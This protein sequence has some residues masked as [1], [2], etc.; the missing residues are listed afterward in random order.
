MPPADHHLDAFG[1]FWVV[2]PKKKDREEAKR[3][4]IAAI[5]RGADPKQMVNAATAYARERGQEDPRYTKFPATWLNKGCYDDEPDPA[6]GQLRAVAGGY[7]PFR[8]PTDQ[9]VYDE[10]LI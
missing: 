4:W 6:A 10:G 2:Y 8:N 1:A 3:A 7:Q 9:S 5:E